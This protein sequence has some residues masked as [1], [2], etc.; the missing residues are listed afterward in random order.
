VTNTHGMKRKLLGIV[1]VMTPIE[2]QKLLAADD[3]MN[4][5][6]RR[7]I[8]DKD[9]KHDI[10]NIIS[11]TISNC[12]DINDKSTKEEMDKIN[13]QLKQMKWRFL[14]ED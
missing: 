6:V 3:I 12:L 11:N 10:Y 2:Y 14:R 7:G 13:T 1:I 9:V 8:N 5:I 4:L